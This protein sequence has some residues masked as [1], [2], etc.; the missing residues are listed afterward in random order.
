MRAL[1]TLFS[2]LSILVASTA[3]AEVPRVLHYQGYLTDA[4]GEPV[5]CPDLVSCPDQVFDITFRLYQDPFG[6]QPLW[7]ETHEAVG[8]HH[9]V[10]NAPLGSLEGLDPSI[11]G[12]PTY[13]GVTINGTGELVPRQEVVS[14][15]FSMRAEVADDATALGGV[16]AESYAT[17]EDL[18]GLCVTHEDLETAI[19]EISYLDESA[20]AAYLTENGYVPGPGFSGNFG[21]LANIPPDLQDGDNDTLAAL[22]CEAGQVPKWD[23][24]SW[25]CS[26]ASSVSGEEV[27]IIVEDMGYAPM[28]VLAPV[29]TSGSYDDLADLPTAV[30]SLD[31]DAGR[32]PAVIAPCA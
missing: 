24:A 8:I 9:G 29:A 15:A 16:P 32:F 19:V 26:Q 20:L 14:S 23:G 28:D 17:L 4:A 18:P 2:T 7:S 22:T 6:G 30:S 3:T 12:D 11:L 1:T 10:F 21:D 5:H 27:E 13:L 31:I 25:V